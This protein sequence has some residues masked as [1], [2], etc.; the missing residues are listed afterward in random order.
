MKMKSSGRKKHLFA[1][2][3]NKHSLGKY[4]QFVSVACENDLTWLNCTET[5]TVPKK[6]CGCCWLLH[7]YQTSWGFPDHIQD[8]E[9]GFLPHSCT[10]VESSSGEDTE[11]LKCCQLHHSDVKITGKL[12]KHIMA[13]WQLLWQKMISDLSDFQFTWF[14]S[15]AWNVDNAGFHTSGILQKCYFAGKSNDNETRCPI[16]KVYHLYVKWKLVIIQE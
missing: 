7:W 15:D 1:L 8:S 12:N 14:W 9:S 11:T 13:D 6:T 10:S 3:S 5:Q 4:F 2:N 16:L